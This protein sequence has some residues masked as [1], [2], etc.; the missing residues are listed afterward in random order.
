MRI[1]V[2]HHSKL[3]G[4]GIPDEDY[5][6]SVFCRQMVALNSSGLMKTA[7]RVVLGINGDASDALLASC[8]LPHEAVVINHGNKSRTE[9]PTL[10]LLRQDLQPGWGVLYHHTKGITHPGMKMYEVWRECMEEAC[11]WGW[12]QCLADLESGAEACGC[13]WLTPERYPEVKSPF[14]GGTFWWARSEYLMSLPP[15]PEPK[16]ENRYE[17]ESWIG[18]GYRRPKVVD[19]H[20]H[21]PG[22]TCG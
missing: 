1:A 5:A 19:Y 21:W 22:L 6:L 10:H 9:L 12:R 17:A 13:H 8:F 2:Y 18:R 11:V 3:R 7:E 4:E 16:W 14:F 20:P 15:V